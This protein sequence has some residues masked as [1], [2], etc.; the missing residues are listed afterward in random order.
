MRPLGQIRYDSG[1]GSIPAEDGVSPTPPAR[2]AVW[3]WLSAA[4]WVLVFGGVI[5]CIDRIEVKT[6]S[7]PATLPALIV[8]GSGTESHA[9]WDRPYAVEFG[10][11]EMSG[12]L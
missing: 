9:Q 7:S 1:V 6:P 2:L 8:Q 11:N 4:F 3:L 12:R 5:W 10:L